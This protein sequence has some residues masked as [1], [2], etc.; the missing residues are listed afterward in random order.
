[1]AEGLYGYSDYGQISPRE[2][3]S[4]VCLYSTLPLLHK[5][6]DPAEVRQV[7]EVISHS[8]LNETFWFTCS[9]PTDAGWTK[10][11]THRSGTML[12]AYRTQLERIIGKWSHD[13]PIRNDNDDTTL[14]DA[15]PMVMK[16]TPQP[17]P[18]IS[19]RDYSCMQS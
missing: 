10:K 5:V 19:A 18:K 13:K 7:W 6:M 12:K 16:M 11:D 1:M 15:N 17:N 14:G 9:T 2:I 4:D 8:T 3:F